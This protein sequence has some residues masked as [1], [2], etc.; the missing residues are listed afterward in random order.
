MGKVLLQQSGK[1]PDVDGLGSCVY[2]IH[3]YLLKT[4]FLVELA[5]VPQSESWEGR[6][7]VVRLLDI[8]GHLKQNIESGD[9]PSFFI[10]EYNLL[11]GENSNAERTARIWILD[12]IL[13]FLSSTDD[14]Q[15]G[16]RDPR[17][18]ETILQSQRPE[19]ISSKEVTKLQEQ[20]KYGHFSSF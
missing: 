17:D 4:G 18:L 11:L 19:C 6:D 16:Q 12:A 20:D 15:L 14:M 10:E 9:M 13:S 8:F 3:T 7:L 5:R 1:V 2:S